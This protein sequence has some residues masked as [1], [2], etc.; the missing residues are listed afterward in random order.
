[1]PDSVHSGSIVREREGKES[2]FFVGELFAS[3]VLRVSM[4][5]WSG[6]DLVLPELVC[7]APLIQF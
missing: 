6:F 3:H 1:V 5:G 4:T 2:M 7:D